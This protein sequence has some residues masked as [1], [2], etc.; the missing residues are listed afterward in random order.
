MKAYTGR[1][2]VDGTYVEVA[3]ITCKDV[4]D[5]QRVAA[6]LQ[7]VNENR[8]VQLSLLFVYLLVQYFYE[9]PNIMP[10]NI[11]KAE[12]FNGLWCVKPGDGVNKSVYL[13]IVSRT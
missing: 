6:L 8:P 10:S 2:D 4:R 9:V 11:V 13:Y 5:G 1:P 3:M 12:A 7:D